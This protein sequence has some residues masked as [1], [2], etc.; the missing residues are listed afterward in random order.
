MSGAHNGAAAEG[1]GSVKE[2]AVIVQA[3]QVQPQQLVQG[4]TELRLVL[5]DAPGGKFVGNEESTRPIK[6]VV[7]AKRKKPMAHNR[8]RK[9]V[10]HDAVVAE[11]SRLTRLL[12]AKDTTITALCRVFARIRIISTHPVTP[13]ITQHRADSRHRHRPSRDDAVF[14]LLR[15]P[16]ETRTGFSESPR[17]GDWIPF[18]ACFA[19]F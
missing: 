4:C 2:E 6:G 16:I 19:C 1:Q 12:E 3:C 8:A 10:A 18:R 11:V 9:K 7:S 15:A 5:V 14:S 13:C 17:H